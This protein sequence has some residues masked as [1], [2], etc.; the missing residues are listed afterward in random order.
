V[1]IYYD[2]TNYNNSLSTTHHVVESTQA[3][4]TALV[5]GDWDNITFSS[6][7][8]TS[9][10]GTTPY[11]ETITLNATGEAFI[12]ME[13]DT[14]VALIFDEDLTDTPPVTVG[15]IAG[16]YG[17]YSENASNDPYIS[18]TYEA[19]VTDHLKSVNGLAKASIKSWNGVILE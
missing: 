16:G 13:G 7:G 5:A 4:T 18:V 15:Q 17:Y 6:I 19:A 8:S 1:N 3:S 14:K 10:G 9:W 12:D 2:G 11:T